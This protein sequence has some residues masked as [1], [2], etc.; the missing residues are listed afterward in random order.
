MSRT[1]ERGFERID[2]DLRVLRTDLGAR[3]DA[4]GAEL[5]SRIDAQGAELGARI[6]ALQRAMIQMGSAMT[7]GILATLVS[8][9]LT[10]A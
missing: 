10:R 4:Q 7:L 1:V 5:S 8:V 2:N 9:V 6:D 3:I